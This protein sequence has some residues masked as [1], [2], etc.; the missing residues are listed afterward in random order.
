MKK[1][2][3]SLFMLLLGAGTLPA[4]VILFDPIVE[5]TQGSAAQD[6]EALYD[7]YDTYIADDFT[8]PAGDDWYIDSIRLY[9]TY[10]AAATAQSGVIISIFENNNGALGSLIFTDTIQ[11]DVDQNGDGWLT[12]NWVGNPI[13]LTPGD[14]WL[15]GSARKDFGLGGGQWFWIREETLFGD[16]AMWSNPGNGFG[17]NCTSFVPFYDCDSLGVTDSGM[18]FRIYGCYGPVKPAGAGL[19]GNDTTFCEGTGFASFSGTSTSNNIGYIWSNGAVTQTINVDSAGAYSVLIYDTITQ[20]GFIEGPRT[21][22]VLPSPKYDIPDDTICPEILP[23]TLFANPPGASILWFN[24]T[25]GL[26]TQVTQAGTYW[27]TYTGSNGCVNTDTMTLTVSALDP[28]TFLPSSTIDLCEGDEVEVGTVDSYSSYE[29]G[30]AI[31]LNTVLA[32][33]TTFNVDEGGTYWLNVVAANGC[34]STGEFTVVD[35]PIPQPTFEFGYTSTLNIELSTAQSFDTYS[36]STGD[37]TRTIIVTENGIY[38]VTVIDEYGCEG[39]ATINIGFVGVEEELASQFNFF[40]N[41]T[42]GI[43]HFTWPN[44]SEEMSIQIMDA[45]GRVVEQLSSSAGVQTLDVNHLTNGI[46]FIHYQTSKGNGAV[47]LVKQ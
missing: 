45:S 10:S 30:N 11:T 9:G 8:V 24:N 12:P 4:Q 40:P 41:P 25:T 3:L 46:Y 23:Y 31:D 7:I 37:D 42:S 19:I 33:T 13:T 6:F 29:W 27:A 32:T 44:L 35:R 16:P 39:S 2:L 26:I 36:W 5:P 17:S 1:R 28:P 34:G 38:S 20:C 47:K 14:Y 18:A 22:N 21:V 43:V 15:V